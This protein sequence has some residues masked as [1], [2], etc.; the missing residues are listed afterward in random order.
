ME[1]ILSS[2]GLSLELRTLINYPDY[3]DVEETGET[4]EENALIKAKA[5]FEYTGLACIADDGGLC[6]DALGGQPGVK[7]RRFL[8]EHS[9]FP[10]KMM[11]ILEMMQ[12]VKGVERSCRFQCCVALVM[13][14]REPFIA[15]GI[16]EG[17]IADAM[18]GMNGFG[19]D[20]IFYLPE[21]RKHMA[22]LSPDEKHRISHRGKALAQAVLYLKSIQFG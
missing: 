10:V 13:P 5:A 4:F 7:S 11:H 2:A 22:E 3:P 20:P 21:L 8:G 19:Y 9:S 16:C 18:S 14:E 15:K 12:D 17:V 6:I 1:Q